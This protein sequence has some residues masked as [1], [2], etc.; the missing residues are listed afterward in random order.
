MLLKY[1]YISS[2]WQSCFDKKTFYGVTNVDGASGVG[3]GAAMW[4]SEP[5]MWGSEVS[6]ANNGVWRSEMWGSWPPSP[7]TLIGYFSMTLNGNQCLRQQNKIQYPILK[8]KKK[9]QTQYKMKFDCIKFS[10]FLE[11][12]LYIL[13]FKTNHPLLTILY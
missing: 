4:G 3:F 2:T 5:L 11:H 7:P 10:I 9:G 13:K 6:F 12:F 8:C 1:L